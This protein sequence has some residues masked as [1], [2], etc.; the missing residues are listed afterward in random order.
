MLNHNTDAWNSCGEYL[1]LPKNQDTK[2]IKALW[3]SLKEHGVCV[4]FCLGSQTAQE[5]KNLGITLLENLQTVS[6]W[7]V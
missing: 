4:M 7:E 2:A 3:N 6:Q 1:F 5:R